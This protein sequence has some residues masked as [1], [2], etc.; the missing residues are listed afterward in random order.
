LTAV[1]IHVIAGVVENES[2]HVLVAQRPAGKRLA[3]AWE[4]PGGKLDAGESRIDGLVREFQE[5]LGM[6]I[7]AARPLIRYRHTYDDFEVDLDVWRVMDWRGTPRGLEGQAMAWH[8][9]EQ[10]LHIGLLPADEAVV[11]AI[12]LPDTFSITPSSA[13]SGT[14]FFLDQLEQ[15]Q[16][17]KLLCLR[18]PDLEVTELLELAAGAA[19]RIEGTQMRLILHGIPTELGPLV[20]DPPAALRAR[21]GN[22]IAGVHVPA[23]HLAELSAR[24]VPASL[25]FGASCHDAAELEAALSLGADYAFLGPVKPT[26]S[27]PGASPLGW[28]RFESLTAGLPLPVYAIGGLAPQDLATAWAAG[29]QGIAGIRGLWPGY[30]QSGRR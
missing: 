30:N 15:I 12:Q 17:A 22:A 6:R 21:L 4:F 14:E 13:P 3:G 5:E 8:P 11:R 2:S 18:R 24:P 16:R 23:R 26:A 7:D 28:D 27:H 1:A 20:T 19:C 10:L 25:W 9:P 29:A